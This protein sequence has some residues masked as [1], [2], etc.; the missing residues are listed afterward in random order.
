MALGIGTYDVVRPH[1]ISVPTYGGTATEAL[2]GTPSVNLQLVR[3][4]GRHGRALRFDGDLQVS[5]AVPGLSGVT[6][7]TIAF[8]V[9]VAEDAP[10]SD[11]YA[12]VAW[13][14]QLPQLGSRPVQI[15][16]NR[17]PGEGPLGALRTDFGGG[18]AIART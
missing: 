4:E 7:H 16:W 10:L 2:V 6:P 18:C 17:R 8:W 15:S 3:S 9:R 1:V 12:M 14:T 13:A 5:G 11:A